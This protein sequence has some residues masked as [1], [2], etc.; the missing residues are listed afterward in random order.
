MTCIPRI[1]RRF[2]IRSCRFFQPCWLERFQGWILTLP[3]PPR[4]YAAMVYVCAG[5]GRSTGGC[6]TRTS[7]GTFSVTTSTSESYTRNYKHFTPITLHSRTIYHVYFSQFDQQAASLAGA[8]AWAGTGVLCPNGC[9]AVHNIIMSGEA[10]LSAENSGK[11]LGG[12]SSAPDP[13]GKL[14][15]LPTAPSW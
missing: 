14:T 8:Y 1:R 2:F 7:S 13:A 11:P 9:M 5:T 12:R 3:P 6:V 4:L 15:V 10:I